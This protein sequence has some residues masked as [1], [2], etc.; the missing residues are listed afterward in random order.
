[1]TDQRIRYATSLQYTKIPLKIRTKSVP[2]V[3]QQADDIGG[4]F[5]RINWGLPENSIANF[6]PC[7]FN[8]KGHRLISFRSQPEPFVFRHDGKYFYYNNT[9]TEVYVGELIS[10]NTIAGARKIR[11]TPHRLSYEDARIFVTPDDELH[12]QFITSSY[13]SKWDSS[14]H[15]MINAPKVCVGSISDFG[16][17]EDCVYPDVGDNHK[18]G[19]PEKNWCFFSEGE[20]L[21]L[22]YS[23]APLVIKTPGQPDKVVDSSS[24]KKLTHD[25]PTFNSTAPIKIGDEWLVFFHWKH[26]VFDMSIQRQVLLYHLGVLTLDENMTKITRQSTE[27]LFTG[28]VEDDLIWWTDV[29]GSPVSTQPACILPFGGSYIE[30]D[31]TIELAL[32]VNDSFMGLFKCPLVNILALLERI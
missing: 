31:D 15:K 23:V 18:S 13:A 11:E 5:T 3:Y 8:H 19:K 32:G 28:A 6:S 30:E 2:T 21:R 20:H 17:V 29:G 10:E 12:L 1:M 7:L 22:L 26:M 16:T 27:P 4:K 9:P 14:K 25:F 24:L